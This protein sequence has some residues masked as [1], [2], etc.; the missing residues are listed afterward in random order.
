MERRPTCKSCQPQ[1][2]RRADPKLVAR[3]LLSTRRKHTVSGT[4]HFQI[5]FLPSP[6]AAGAED[7]LKRA[8]RIYSAFVD[9]ASV[10]R[11]VSSVLG[12]P[13]VRFKLNPHTRKTRL[14]TKT[15]G[16]GTVKMRRDSDTPKSGIRK[17]RSPFA[18]FRS[19][20]HAAPTAAT[21][22][23]QMQ[24]VESPVDGYDE[25]EESSDDIVDDG[26]SSSS[27]DEDDDIP[28][29]DEND[30]RESPSDVN[31]LNNQMYN[32]TLGI[33]GSK[34]SD[35]LTKMS[36]AGKKGNAAGSHSAT[37]PGYFEQHSN[38]TQASLDS[39]SE[40]VSVADTP[41][42]T[43][44]GGRRKMFKRNRN[45]RPSMGTSKKKSKDFNFDAKDGREVLGIVIMEISGAEDL[46]RLKSCEFA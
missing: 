14:T 21:G 18:R 34:P 24:P 20:V 7:A 39:V 40:S 43:P 22:G 45:K 37:G 30:F 19:S 33:P 1:F 15:Q 41:S 38:K 6:E 29:Q 9:Q 5:G 16:I 26:L 13:A 10:G 42:M 25:D 4:V 32:A 46:P 17:S 31:G 27:S 44:G 11:G 23:H 8:R 35:S 12:V 3:R 28:E 2:D 36:V